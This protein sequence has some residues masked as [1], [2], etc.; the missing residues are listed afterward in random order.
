MTAAR[1][2]S[3]VHP[4]IAFAVGL[5][6]ALAMPAG[7]GE[8][9][10]YARQWPLATQGDA[11][12]YRLALDR[13]VYR[14]AIQPGLGDIEVFNA[15]G[16]S[17]PAALFAADAP[18]PGT[19]AP[20]ALPWF[21]LPAGAAARAGDITVIS[22]RA[23]D[24]SIRRV[25]A[26]IA[27]APAPAPAATNAWLV[28]ASRVRARLGALRLAWSAQAGP[29][30]VEISVEGSDDLR[31]WRVLQPRAQLLDLAR[32]GQRL[33]QSRVPLDG[34]ARY[35]RIATLRADAALPL[36]GVEAEPTAMAEA[37]DWRWE[38]LRGRAASERGATH[39]DFELDGRFPVARADIDADDNAAGTWTLSSRDAP[40]A[41]W[42][43]RAGPWVAF[44]VATGDA[45]QRS[46]AQALAGV[47]RD[48]YWRL[49]PQSATPGAPALR[50]GYRPET[51]V[52]VAQGAGPYALAAGSARAS[53]V[54]APLQ[55]ML[56]ALR[57]SRGDTWQPAMASI[58]AAQAL[59]G[60]RALQPRRDWKHWLLWALLVGGALV[61]AGFAFSLLRKGRDPR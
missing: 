61:V 40:D 55:P 14:G 44:S 33:R 10:D 57:A 7:A 12:A 34:Q 17:V 2:P 51:L 48:R 13:D 35:L 49:T 53:R 31:D 30:D 52:F 20:F 15:A 24:G 39:Y 26:R 41:P 25:E 54:D 5:L 38:V 19:P 60:E 32:G 37:P 27:D 18:L 4:G 46:P 22:E 6:V 47:V 9:D 29:L 42:A 16:Q 21:P 23:A 45:P 59:A 1:P 36:S 11:G 58:G 8:R 50:L 3:I 43:V 56:D 28:D